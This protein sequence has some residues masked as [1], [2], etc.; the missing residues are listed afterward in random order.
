MII[1]ELTERLECV[2]R[3]NLFLTQRLS[4][5][6]YHLQYLG[7]YGMYPMNH[8][9]LMSDV[10]RTPSGATSGTTSSQAMPSAVLSNNENV[11][12]ASILQDENVPP[13]SILQDVNEANKV[14]PPIDRDALI[15]PEE[16]LVRYPH[17]VVKSKFTKL[18]V[19]LAKEAFFGKL[20][21][22]YCTYKG[23]RELP[24]LPDAEVERFKSF[25]RETS[26]PRM[27]TSPAE[28]EALYNHC[29]NSVGQACKTLRMQR[30][31]RQKLQ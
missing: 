29:V 1:N 21:M 25:L 5:I 11:P 19:K 7:Y 8:P 15:R 28:F 9:M 3:S 10:L 2:E 18:A 6:E 12:P 27:V 16:V 24:G 17:F 4:T 22:S 23:A 30:L 20:H 14:P 31:A 13:A 26:M